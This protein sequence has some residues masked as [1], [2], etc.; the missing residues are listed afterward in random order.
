VPAAAEARFDEI[1]AIAIGEHL[2]DEAAIGVDVETDRRFG[3]IDR[4]LKSTALPPA[5]TSRLPPTPTVPIAVSP[6]AMSHSVPFL[7]ITRCVKTGSCGKRRYFLRSMV[8]GGSPL[9]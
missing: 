9:A 7:I 8:S 4:L 5:S 2:P 3:M 6:S 1:V